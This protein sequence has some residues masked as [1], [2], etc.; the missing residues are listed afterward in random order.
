MHNHALGP[1][2]RTVRPIPD[3]HRAYT[4]PPPV[5]SPP[6][7]F[8]LIERLLCPTCMNLECMMYAARP[9]QDDEP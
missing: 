4:H 5:F 9:L 2:A 1:A 6:F 7:L 8:S 3:N